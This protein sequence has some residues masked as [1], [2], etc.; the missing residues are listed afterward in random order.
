MKVIDSPIPANV[1]LEMAESFEEKAPEGYE[2][3]QQISIKL[4]RKLSATKDHV[5][6]MMEAGLLD[7][8]VIG[9]GRVK[10]FRPKNY[11]KQNKR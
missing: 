9:S 11:A 2:N 5:R 3:Y 1:W 6:R 10:Y 8:L 7:H 4:G